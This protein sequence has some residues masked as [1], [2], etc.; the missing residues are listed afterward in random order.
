[1][2]FFQ[3]S[4]NYVY[5]EEVDNLKVALLRE[6]EESRDKL[7]PTIHEELSKHLK[8]KAETT[9]YMKVCISI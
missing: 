1:M 8:S 4:T 3:A 6:K 5:G 2:N 7:G 9:L